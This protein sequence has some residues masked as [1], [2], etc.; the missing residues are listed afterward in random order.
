MHIGRLIVSKPNIE[1]VVRH[2]DDQPDLCTSFN[3][4]DDFYEKVKDHYREESK[5][6][7]SNPDLHSLLVTSHAEIEYLHQLILSQVKLNDSLEIDDLVLQ[8]VEKVMLTLGNKPVVPPLTE[9]LKK[10]HLGTIE[11]ARD[12]LFLNF[13]NKISLQQLADHCCV[14]LFHFSRIFKEVMNQSPY[15]YLTE[16]RLNH[17]KLLLKS[18][19]QS[20]TEIAFQ[21][22]FNSLEHF[23]T[24]FKQRYKSSPNVLRKSET[25]T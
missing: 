23:A 19:S 20:I 25:V 14:S 11:K 22:G 18:T 21:S 6:F 7:F 24:S 8:L 5:W 12:F 10:Y 3:F 9:R 15:Q 1:Y 2:I 17:S 13:S 16:L 4:T